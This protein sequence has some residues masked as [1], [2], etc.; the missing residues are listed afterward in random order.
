LRR[1][2]F[3][4]D[5]GFYYLGVASQPYKRGAG[6]LAEPPY[7]TKPS[8]PF[9][10]DAALQPPVRPD[11]ARPPTARCLGT[12]QQQ[13]TLFDSGFYFFPDQFDANRQS[14]FRLGLARIDERMAKLVQVCSQERIA[15]ASAIC[16]SSGDALIRV[17]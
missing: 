2:A 1:L 11:G 4:L 16:R 10:F 12:S 17:L 8:I 6:A 13:Q 3:Q 14:N 15:H 9:F 7:S 5:L